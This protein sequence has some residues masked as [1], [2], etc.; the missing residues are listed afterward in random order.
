METL[1]E[2]GARHDREMKELMQNQLVSWQ[3]LNDQYGRGNIPDDAYKQW[4]QQHGNAKLHS[5]R[6]Q[7]MAEV[8]FYPNSPYEHLYQAAQEQHPQNPAE[9]QPEP[10]KNAPNATESWEQLEKRHKQEWDRYVEDRDK[11]HKEVREQYDGKIPMSV[12]NEIITYDKKFEA[13]LSAQQYEEARRHP[14]LPDY[15]QD[16][17][18]LDIPQAYNQ[19]NIDDRQPTS[20]EPEQVDIFE[21]LLA[22]EQVQQRDHE[23]NEKLHPEIKSREMRDDIFAQLEGQKQQENQKERDLFEQLEEKQSRGYKGS[24]IDQGFDY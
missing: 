22:G 14:D 5:L 6:A 24:K 21:Q 20:K 12:V 9:P 11:Y 17:H 8:E 15:L 7:H 23:M 1:G 10:E 13:S 16:H 4:D 19:S 18:P 2:M 3:S